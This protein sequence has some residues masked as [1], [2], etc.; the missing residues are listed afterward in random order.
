LQEFDLCLDLLA[1]LEQLRIN[2]SLTASPFKAVAAA[3]KS[4][5]NL[6]QNPHPKN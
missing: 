6:L 4:G 2:I 3:A 5:F 1:I